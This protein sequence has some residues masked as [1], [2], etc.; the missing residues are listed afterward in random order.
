M[1]NYPA[2]IEENLGLLKI[3]IIDDDNVD[4]MTIKRSLRKT[5]LLTEVFTADTASKGI[6]MLQEKTFDCVFLDFKL[7]DMDGLELL[8][9]VQEIEIVVPI[10]VVT[11]H[12]D[13][14]IAA[15]AIRLGAA[16]YIPKNFLTPEGIYH[17][18][19]SAL[20]IH[21][22]EQSRLEA[23]RQFKS[24][25]YQLEFIISN[26]P[27][28]FW[29]T[30]HNGV[31]T[32][33]EGKVFE[34]VGIDAA[35]VLGKHYSIGFAE[36]PAIVQRF[37]SAFS[38]ETI[39]SVLEY[40]GFYFRSHYVPILDDKQQITGITGFAFDITDS[41]LNE[42]AL[43]KAK[44]IAEESV[45]VKE[46]FI[47]SVSH[48]IRT[49][50][51]GIL[52]LANVLQKTTLDLHQKKYLK[53]IQTSADNL[54]VIINDLLD[55]S[56]ISA[57]KLTFDQEELNIEEL[58]EDTV[59]LLESK[60]QEKNNALTYSS[61]Q[62]VPQT[63][64]GD[65]LRLKQVLLNL[66]GNAI[67]FTQDGKI[68][69]SVHMYTETE[70]AAFLEFKVED[71]GIGIPADKLS[72]IFESFNQGSNDTTRKYG[73]TGLGLTISKDLVELQGGFISV[74]SQPNIGSTFTFTLPFK[75]QLMTAGNH[76]SESEAPASTVDSIM[77]SLRVLL[78]EDNE[79]NQLL[80]NTVLSDWGV[81]V[82]IANNGVEALAYYN[83]QSYD[84]ILMDMQM[85]EMDGYEAIGK[86][87]TS[88]EA[89]YNLPIIALTAH[90]AAEE[91][92]KCLEA[93]ANS[94]ISKP[95]EPEDLHDAILTLLKDKSVVQPA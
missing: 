28:S 68:N 52:G 40:K 77:G 55:F 49:P 33:A 23:E 73:G 2:I 18:I 85:P 59:L 92:A 76:S 1:I 89:G 74:K 50:M 25:Q 3:L 83:Q 67:K 84:I 65:A 47:A 8:Q 41:V 69:L 15:N 54:M 82:D 58:A 14:R 11:S 46:Q 20:R 39:Q 10:L 42:R 66:I 87:R 72:S 7:P 38:G 35:Y 75:K 94:H 48:E 86:I 60:A 57:K 43:E 4:Q 13:E 36:S 22:V 31:L 21:K 79:I 64:L 78:A 32:Y 19:N 30:D 62:S 16:D 12:G 90:A 45:R 95:F 56:K 61:S 91:I 53:A 71:T 93:G 24:S 6:Q 29:R 81:T 9:K 5:D 88:S 27:M 80:I 37:K 26:S 34:M 70:E 63:V 17:S 51:N 44:E